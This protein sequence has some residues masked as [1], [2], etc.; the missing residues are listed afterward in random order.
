MNDAL[1]NILKN[2]RDKDGNVIT[3]LQDIQEAFGYIPRKAVDYF[4]KIL[5]IPGSRIY[6]VVTFYAQFRLKP[7]GKHKITACCGTACHVRGSEKIIN[8]LIKELELPA[9]EDTTADG[10][11]TLEKVACLGTCSFAPIALVD[12]DVRGKAKTENLIKEIRSLKGK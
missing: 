2:H 5:G 6:G 9:G 3:L 1:N 4:S 7:A 11:F 12:G 10:E 8:R